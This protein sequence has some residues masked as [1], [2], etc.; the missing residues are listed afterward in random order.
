ML[1]SVLRD[2]EDAGDEFARRLYVFLHSASLSAIALL[3]QLA[4]EL[5]R[6]VAAFRPPFLQVSERNP[7][8][9][10][11]AVVHVPG[12]LSPGGTVEW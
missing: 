7:T 3:T 5:G 2:F 6:I 9:T 10:A 1:G 12:T 8:P 4:A 11:A